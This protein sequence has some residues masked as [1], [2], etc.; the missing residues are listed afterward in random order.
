MFFGHRSG[1]QSH[2]LGLGGERANVESKQASPEG[3]TGLLVIVPRDQISRHVSLTG[4]FAGLPGCQVIVDRRVVQ[5]RHAAAPCRANERR[6]HE[7]RTGHLE[8]S[9]DRVVLLR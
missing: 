3:P 5:R 8:Y 6:Q 7:R 2:G 1:N 9:R 4:E